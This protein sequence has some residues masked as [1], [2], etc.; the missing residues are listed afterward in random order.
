[1]HCMVNSNGYV[2]VC[3]CLVCTGGPQGILRDNSHA[4][5]LKWS[6]EAYYGTKPSEV[7][8]AAS[9]HAQPTLNR[10]ASAHLTFLNTVHVYNVFG[11]W[12]LPS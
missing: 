5:T 12:Q 6:M 11:V 9:G 8:F 4:V 1:M 7:F 2:C 3:V 10:L